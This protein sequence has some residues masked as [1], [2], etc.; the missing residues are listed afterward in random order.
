[1]IQIRGEESSFGQT[2]VA[3]VVLITRTVVYAL[4]GYNLTILDHI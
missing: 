2:I 1:M 4:A 3:K